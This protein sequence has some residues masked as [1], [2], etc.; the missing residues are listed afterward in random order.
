[1]EVECCHL[2]IRLTLGEALLPS[3][4]NSITNTTIANIDYSMQE[5]DM[6]STVEKCTDGTQ[7]PR[8]ASFG[9]LSHRISKLIHWC[10]T[11]YIN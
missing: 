8:S 4:K 11:V 3:N 6:Y 2:S 5:H 1:M 10:A 7:S 9:V